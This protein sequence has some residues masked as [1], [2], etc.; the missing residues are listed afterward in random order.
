MVKLDCHVTKNLAATE[1][2]REVEVVVVLLPPHTIHRLQPLDVAFFGPF[3]KYYDDAL[4]MWM[5][6]HVGRHGKS[7]K[8]LMW[9][10]EKRHPSK[11]LLVA[12]R[13]QVCG[14]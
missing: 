9:L 14:Y 7:P 2:A 10:T 1:M 5:R 12:S 6:E 11:M 8:F 3:G 4:R 13:R